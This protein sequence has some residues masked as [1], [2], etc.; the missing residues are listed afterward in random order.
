MNVSVKEAQEALDLVQTMQRRVHRVIAEGYTSSLLVLWGGIWAVGFLALHIL[1]G[2]RG[3]LVFGILDGVGLVATFLLIRRAPHKQAIRSPQEG[4]LLWQL[5]GLWIALFLYGALWLL[6]F[7][8]QTGLQLGVFLCTLSMFAYVV[9]G[10]WLRCPFMIWLGLGVTALT[11]LGY[12]LLPA[13]FYLWMAVVGSSTLIGT[14]LYIRR[15][16]R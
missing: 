3:G 14:G 7:K 4:Q 6:L 9:M 13:F 2:P 15:Y 16:W 11:L 5:W 12:T 10:L 8:P 1:G